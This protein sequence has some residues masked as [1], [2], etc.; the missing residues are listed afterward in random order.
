MELIRIKSHN[1][2][3]LLSNNCEK[4]YKYAKSIESSG[5]YG[6]IHSL[7]VNVFENVHNKSLEKQSH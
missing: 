5:R 6:D 1:I 2:C 3:N 7:K 4:N